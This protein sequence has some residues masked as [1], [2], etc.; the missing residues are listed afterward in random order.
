MRAQA[1]AARAAPNKVKGSSG[2][3]GSGAW[4][5][6]G[7]TRLLEAANRCW[8]GEDLRSLQK[9]LTKAAQMSLR[10]WKPSC[11]VFRVVAI[12]SQMFHAGAVNMRV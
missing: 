9:A 11:R 6:Q 2:E 3:R 4:G 8:G 12:I 5:P 7:H 10:F 1:G